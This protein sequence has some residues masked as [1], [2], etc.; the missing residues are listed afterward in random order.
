[1]NTFLKVVFGYISRLG[2]VLLIVMCSYNIIPYK[3]YDYLILI[4]AIAYSTGG[5]L[6]D[7]YSE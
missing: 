6:K 5:L 1:M 3:H 7:I 2:L 4:G